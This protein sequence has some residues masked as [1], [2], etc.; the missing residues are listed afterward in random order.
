MLKDIICKV[1]ILLVL[2]FWM[3]VVWVILNLLILIG[4]GLFNVGNWGV[5]YERE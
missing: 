4:I 3:S 5:E 2:F 1:W